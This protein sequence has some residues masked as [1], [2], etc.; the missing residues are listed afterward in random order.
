[1]LSVLYHVIGHVIGGYDQQMELYTTQNMITSFNK[2][3]LRPVT[4]NEPLPPFPV[5]RTLI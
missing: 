5:G 3:R 4:I 1:M 2:H